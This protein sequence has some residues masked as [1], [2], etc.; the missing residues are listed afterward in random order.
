VE[1]AARVF[2]ERGYGGATTDRIADRAGVSIGS[3]MVTSPPA[4]DER[5]AV[6]RQKE[7]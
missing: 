7:R 5:P 6:K 4:V 3:L 1:A 2:E